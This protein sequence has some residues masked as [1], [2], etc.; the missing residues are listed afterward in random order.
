MHYCNAAVSAAR[1]FAH[2]ARSHHPQQGSALSRVARY[3]ARC[4][5]LRM[6][7]VLFAF[8]GA[9]TQ[10]HADGRWCINSDVIQFGNRVVGTSTNSTVTVTN[11]GDQPGRSPTSAHTTGPASRQH[12]LHDRIDAGA[13]PGGTATIQ[14]APLVAGQT[15]GCWLRNT[16]NTPTQLLTFYGRGVDAQASTA[17]PRSSGRRRFSGRISANNQRR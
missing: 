6:A 14:F 3:L 1:Y 9:A 16:T 8:A 11:C 7:V 10:A 2:A 12:Q 15:S 5:V 13:H 4:R 17:T